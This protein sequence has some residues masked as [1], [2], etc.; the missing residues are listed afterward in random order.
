MARFDDLF[1]L[2]LLASI[3]VAWL[4]LSRLRELAA[5]EARRQCERHGLQLLDETVGLSSLRLRRLDGMRVIERGYS[6]EVSIDGNDREPGRLWLAH[7]RVTGLS[8]PTIEARIPERNDADA[9][10]SNVVP[11]RPRLEGRKSGDPRIH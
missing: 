1:L 11:L 10:A 5:A 2:L 4:K 8:L 9:D 3:V 6:F 7:G